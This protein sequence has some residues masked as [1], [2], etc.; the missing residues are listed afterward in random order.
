MFITKASSYPS[1]YGRYVITCVPVA[2]ENM[3]NIGSQGYHWTSISF[4]CCPSV[5]IWAT[6]IG[7]HYDAEPQQWNIQKTCKTYKNKMGSQNVGG[8]LTFVA[9]D[10]VLGLLGRGLEILT[11]Q[12]G[13][14]G[15]LLYNLAGSFAG[16]ILP[17]YPVPCVEFW[18]RHLFPQ[19]LFSNW[20]HFFNPWNG[21]LLC[22][23]MCLF[24]YICGMMICCSLTL[25]S[26]R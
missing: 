11:I 21:S 6:C 13:G 15:E 22:I 26:S 10:F 8:R 14:F 3:V 24:K 1:G 17:W 12:L 5:L 23:C 4:H 16:S 20:P 18:L 19:T 25:L 2:T 9:L 7:S